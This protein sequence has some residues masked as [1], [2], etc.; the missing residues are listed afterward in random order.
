MTREP[1]LVLVGFLL[2]PLALMV[3]SVARAASAEAEGEGTTQPAPAFT[4]DLSRQLVKVPG[5]QPSRQGEILALSETL[6]E[7][8][9]PLDRAAAHLAIANWHLAVPPAMSATRWLMGLDEAA[10]RRLIAESAKIASVDIE[11]AQAVLKAARGQAKKRLR[12]LNSAAE[13]LGLFVDLFLIVD[14]K[15][16]GE[17]Y[18]LTCADTALNLAIAR[19]SDDPAVASCALLW[20]S[21]AFNLAERRDRALVSLPQA[22]EAPK[23]LPY[24]F[25]SRLLRCKILAELGRYA[26]ATGLSIR[27]RAACQQW[28]KGET[29]EGITARCRLAALLQCRIGQLWMEQLS[30]SDSKVA[31]SRLEASLVR[32]QESVFSSEQPQEV[33]YLDPAV[34][35]I[36]KPPVIKPPATSTAPATA[37]APATVPATRSR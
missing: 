22:L 3:S 2:V 16:E 24:D 33:Y 34:P 36:V 28:F 29:D 18:R 10:D 20:Q 31:A 25:M 9:D 21:F 13:T 8:E 37:S 32:L 12:E 35:I 27:I 6:L 4:L 26:A 1:V 14:S 19:E 7:A 30:S 17:A 23:Y 11:R 5:V 15:Q